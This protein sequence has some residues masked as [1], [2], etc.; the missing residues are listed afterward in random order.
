MANIAPPKPRASK[1]APPAAGESAGALAKPTE[2]AGSA[3][4]VPL[5]FKVEEAFRTDLKIA[6]AMCDMTMAAVIQEAYALWKKE[7]GL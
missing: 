4:L 3:T 7:K 6:A 5:N 2:R 1:G